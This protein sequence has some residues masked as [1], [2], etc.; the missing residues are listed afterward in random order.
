MVS[1]QGPA[2]ALPSA[3]ET[4]VDTAAVG[5]TVLVNTFHLRHFPFNCWSTATTLFT[6]IVCIIIASPTSYICLPIG[7][8]FQCCSHVIATRAVI[9]VCKLKQNQIPKLLQFVNPYA[10]PDMFG[11][12]SC[13]DRIC[14]PSQ[15][16]PEECSEHGGKEGQAAQEGGRGGMGGR[17]VVG[18]SCCCWSQVGGEQVVAVRSHSQTQPPPR[19]PALHHSICTC[20]CSPSCSSLS[21]RPDLLLRIGQVIGGWSPRDVWFATSTGGERGVGRRSACDD[22]QDT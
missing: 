17:G 21:P 16:L 18:S 13:V 12:A 4:R 10:Y 1:S 9:Y 20:C 22:Q 11:E 8:R 14:P 2:G 5:R 15:R 7:P 6:T 3:R 19:S